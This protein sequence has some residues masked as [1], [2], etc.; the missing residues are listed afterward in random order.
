MV[1]CVLKFNFQRSA[2]ILIL[3]LWVSYSSLLARLEVL[4]SA[5][6]ETEVLLDVTISTGK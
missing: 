1:F 6:T 5:F 2:E 4:T 3:F